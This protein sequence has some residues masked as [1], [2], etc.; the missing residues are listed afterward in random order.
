MQ[1]DLQQQQAAP[2]NQDAAAPQQ[3]DAA[4]QQAAAQPLDDT[5]L[6]AAIRYNRSLGLTPDQI[7]HYQRILSTGSDGSFGPD[8]TRAI[9][10][11]QSSKP[12]LTADGKLGPQ[13]RAALDGDHQAARNRPP[14]EAR[15]LTEQEI[16]AAIRYNRG[17][18]HDA[19]MI[20]QIQEKVG[21]GVDGS[22]GADTVQKIWSWQQQNGLEADGRVGPRTLERMGIAGAD[23]EQ[24]EREAGTHGQEGTGGEV[25][26][27]NITQNISWANYQSNGQTVPRNLRP[28]V[29]QV[30]QE[31]EKVIAAFGG[32]RIV[33]NSGYRSP[34][35]NRSIGGASQSQHTMGRACDFNI[36]GIRP[37][38]VRQKVEQLIR[39]GQ[40]RQGGLGAYANFTHYDIRGYRARW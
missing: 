15:E 12:G 38:A 33:I 7:K 5:M 3:A 40:M 39:D 24:A 27:G 25:P 19:A 2:Q 32:R 17:R 13:T 1:A 6:Q 8:T 31:L 21:A 36:Q 4:P 9:H 14:G 22:I 35:Y 16:Q 26:S 34:A 28:L 30:C 20:R 37:S 29:T 11:Y 18:Y 23:M 10:T